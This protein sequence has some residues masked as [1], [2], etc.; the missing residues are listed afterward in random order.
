MSWKNVKIGDVCLVKRGSTI[1]EKQAVKGSIPVV[2]GGISYSY[3]HNQANR[4]ANVITVSA[5]GANAGYVN[6]WDIPI[7]ASDCSTVEAIDKNIN[8]RFIFY[9]LRSKQD[10]INQTMRSGA[11]QPHVYAKDIA[12]I[13]LKLPPLFEQNRIA[14]ILDK[15]NEVKVK[16]QL[17]LLKLDDLA[18]SIFIDM[19][20]DPLVNNFNFEICSIGDLLVSANYGTSEKSSSSGTHPVLRMN[21]ITMNGD[22]DITNLKYMNLHVND[23]EKYL[24]KSGDILFNRTNSPELVGKTALFELN[25]QYAYAGYLIRLRSNSTADPSYIAAYLNTKF[26]KKILRNMCKSIVGMANINA[27]EIQAM[28]IMRPPIKRQLEFKNKISSIKKIKSIYLRSITK[29]SRVI[30]SLESQ[31]FSTGFNA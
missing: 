26:A 23:Y 16:R 6:F 30:K 24:V 4:S 2:A 31:A 3:K 29:H 13:S 12:Q 8:I 25:D 21:N 9:F 15:A 19:F 22:I 20:G 10:F 17:A 11:A 5:S 7:F 18:H 28:K 1:T 14:A 27:K